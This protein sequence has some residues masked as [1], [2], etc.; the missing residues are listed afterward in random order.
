MEEEIEQKVLEITPISK[1]KRILSFLADF[2]LNFIFCFVI[3]NV[4]VMPISNAITNSEGRKQTSNE[5][6]YKQFDILYGNKLLFYEGVSDKYYYNKDVELTMDCYLSYYSFSDS[7]VLKDHPILG[8]K[9]D[10]EVLLHFYRDIR[11]DLPR[12]LSTLQEFNKT[13]NYFVI[14]GDNISL[15]A[16]IRNDIRFS[17]LSPN[18]MSSEGKTYLAN[19]QNFFVNTFAD[20]F[21]AI[22]KNDLTFEGESYLANKAI[23]SKAESD[24]QWQLVF[25]S[26]IAYFVSSLVY[27]LIIPLINQN[28]KTLGMMMMSLERIGTNNLYLINK[29]EVLVQF[30]YSLVFDIAI[31]F[32]MPMTYVTFAYLFNISMLPALLFIGLLLGLVSMTVI[33]ASPLNRSICDYFSKSVM[34]KSSDLDAIYR[35]KG[36]D[37]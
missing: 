21:K 30:A 19:M 22:E 8:H 14:D 29:A 15:R 25:S 20:V 10:N 5:A 18:D 17:F 13:Y 35:S 33:I 12:Y 2:F 37:V 28:N 31:T 6:A 4:V 11:N 27:F 34:I 32:F 1:V 26:L 9:D 23:V 7:D 24:L 3:F 16:S 36:Y